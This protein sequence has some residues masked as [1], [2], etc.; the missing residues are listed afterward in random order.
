MALTRLRLS[1]PLHA[2]ILAWISLF[3][4]AV[5]FALAQTPSDPVRETRNTALEPDD[6][7]PF[8]PGVRIRWR[9]RVVEI[10]A[11]VVLREGP[12]E[13][14]AC[15][16]QTREHE[17]IFAIKARPL[18]VHQAMGLIGLL[19]GNPVTFQK[20][21]QALA[22]PRGAKVLIDVVTGKGESSRTMPAASFVR[23]AG[24][25]KPV[26]DVDWV[27]AGSKTMSSGRYAADSEGTVI[28]LVD[29][30]TALIAVGA[31]HSADNEALWV[32]ANTDAIPPLDES[33]VI[34]IRPR[35]GPN[36]PRAGDTVDRKEKDEG[37]PSADPKK[38]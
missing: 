2:R 27:F 10:D 37:K 38:P 29:F 6:A 1:S 36:V 17:S 33:V 32:E 4:I 30:D 13:L 18:H 24:D 19:P 35:E 25:R 16:P 14:F 34:R 8:A 20:E 31:L 22:P 15:S 9:D 23:S 5:Q 26:G 28:A 21:T 3:P 12:L 11:R 7:K